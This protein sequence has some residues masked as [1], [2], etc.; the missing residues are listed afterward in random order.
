MCDTFVSLTDD[1]VLFGKNSDRD[2]NEAQ[3]VQWYAAADHVAGEDLRCTWSTIP[4]VA[5]TNAVVLSQ[6][7]WMWGAE[8]GANEHGVVI[9]N[10]AVF[11]RRA[12]RPRTGT[13]LLG[14]DLL[15]LALE[16]AASAE[17]AVSVIVDLL[18]RHGQGGS[19]SWEH[20][21]FTYDNSFLIADRSGAFVLETAGTAWASEQ[22]TTRGRSISNALTIAPFATTYADRAREQVGRAA[23]RRQCTEAAARTVTAPGEVMAALREH[24]F[25]APQWNTLTGA[26]SAPCVH[27]GGA[28]VSTQSTASWVADLRGPGVH[29]VT[30]ASAPCTATFLPLRVEESATGLDPSPV[31]RPLRNVHDPDHRWW[32][33]ERLH[34]LVLRDHSAAMARFRAERDALEAGWLA[35]APQD[36]PTPAD[37]AAVIDAA[38]ARWLADLVESGLPDRRPSWLRAL[39]RRLDGA[40]H[41]PKELP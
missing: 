31:A 26:L 11:T 2:A 30:G 39:W 3:S 8:M 34:R 36:L 19:C 32:R 28:V 35:L 29:W 9:G 20:R 5:H 10:E 1:G 6:P 18:E 7:W 14:M 24:E 22:V 27:A 12:P 21:R 25:A 13:E 16:R 37:A 17:E 33:H 15:R 40:A 38:E 4:Q 23:Q 41:L